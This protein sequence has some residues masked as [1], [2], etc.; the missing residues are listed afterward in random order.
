MTISLCSLPVAPHE[1]WNV[2]ALLNAPPM[3]INGYNQLLTQWLAVGK[4]QQTGNVCRL[5]CDLFSQIPNDLETAITQ[6][7]K[8]SKPYSWQV[9]HRQPVF[10]PITGKR[11]K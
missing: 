2:F 7:K 10:Q 3:P 5:L 1:R 4:A 8:L 9:S 6:W 11:H